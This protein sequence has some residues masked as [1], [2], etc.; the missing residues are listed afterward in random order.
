[1]VDR[2]GRCRDGFAPGTSKWGDCWRKDE[3]VVVVGSR[4][5]VRGSRFEGTG[6]KLEID[7]TILDDRQK[8][9]SV[10]R[11]LFEDSR[12]TGAIAGEITIG[13]VEGR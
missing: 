9:T 11:T 12:P 10:A 4:V 8:L 3:E 2:A 13:Y 1:M 5:E 6:S 7:L